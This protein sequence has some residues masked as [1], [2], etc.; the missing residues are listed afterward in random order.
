MTLEQAL[1][2]SENAAIANM[3]FHFRPAAII[4]EKNKLPILAYSKTEFDYHLT[5]AVGN[6][7]FDSNFLLAKWKLRRRTDW[8]PVYPSASA[9]QN[10]V[11][12]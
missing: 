10:P 7:G 1:E 12:E 11:K 4:E 2:L 9:A 6:V 5:S 8:K 3:V